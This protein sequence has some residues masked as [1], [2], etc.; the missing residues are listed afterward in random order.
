[1]AYDTRQDSNPNFDANGLVKVDGQDGRR[2]TD[3]I[4]TPIPAGVIASTGF[5][6]PLGIQG[7]QQ[8][9]PMNTA[10]Q[11][12][13]AGRAAGPLTRIVQGIRY[14]ISGA[15]PEAWMGPQQP[16]V[17]LAQQQTEGR[18][19]DYPVGVNLTRQGAGA[20]TSDHWTLRALADNHDVTRLAIE[21]RKDQ[22]CKLKPKIVHEDENE[23]VSDD[24]DVQAIAAQ[25]RFPDNRHTWATW[26]RMLMEEVLVI[27]A[28]CVYP[29]MSLGGNLWGLD[30]IDGATIK[31]LIDDAGRSPMPPD[32]CYQQWLKGVPAAD[33]SADQLVYMPRNPRVW[34]LYGFSPVE[35]ILMTVNIALRRQVSQLQYYTEGNIPEVLLGT[36]KEW[37]AAQ[38]LS[39]Q[40]YWDSVIE[41]QQQ[42]KRKAKFVPGDVKPT[43]IRENPMKDEF[44]E[45]LA[46]VVCFCFSLP[47][48]AFVKQM[49]RATAETAQDAAL[50]EGLAPLMQWVCDFMDLI[51]A[52]HFKR[53][54]LRFGWESQKTVDPKVQ[55]EIDDQNLRNA[56]ATLDEIRATR[57]LEPYPNKLGADPL[58]FTA[59]GV[60]PLKTE[61]ENALNPPPPPPGLLGA[62]A[63]ADP[64]APAPK[65]G[66]PAPKPAP[67]AKPAAAPAQKR[68]PAVQATGLRETHV[69]KLA[70]KI[71]AVLNT[72]A[73][74]VADQLTKVL[75]LGTAEKAAADSGDGINPANQR[76]VNKAVKALDMGALLALTD[77]MAEAVAE[78]AGD[79]VTDSLGEVGID[80]SGITDLANTR[81]EAYAAKRSAALITSDADGGK[82]A[83]ATRDMIRGTVLAAVEDGSSNQQLTQSLM[84]SYAFSPERAETIARTEL[85]MANSQGALIGYKAS[86]VVDGKQWQCSNN[87]D[88]CDICQAN[89]DAGV[90]DLDDEFPDGSD[91][92]P[93]H[94]NCNCVVVPHLKEDE[95]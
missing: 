80:D 54:D 53:P 73:Q 32:A 17:P 33:Y 28:P 72:L 16:M 4:R 82:L 94:P 78:A 81:A 47:P 60:A 84:D 48:T 11:A 25:L 50:S 74:Q 26:L 37:N 83:R 35:Q 43:M 12:A 30:L 8:Y 22:M 31:P 5:A 91:T 21:T 55:T 20:H 76:K 7:Q 14:M 2:K 67:A 62:P 36:P 88:C 15:G 95:T 79:G 45:W 10:A 61:I 71:A 1:M 70:P 13:A 24:P 44:D 64:N 51:L 41:G 63:D 49:N 90:V 18:Q 3:G 58:V 56:S 38:V 69:S 89:E 9:I 77:D 93:A 86:G 59:T 57:G 19:F 75:G 66:E 65:P 92:T 42:F 29:R 23:D 85:K 34:K 52:K 46:R 6:A 39:A 27:D 40:N 68:A 87:G